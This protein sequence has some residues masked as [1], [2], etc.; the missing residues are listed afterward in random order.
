MYIPDNRAKLL[1]TD[2][3]HKQRTTTKQKTQ[4]I[5]I[6]MICLNLEEIKNNA[7]NF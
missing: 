6:N 2:G 1:R 5:V 7:L 4:T 3:L